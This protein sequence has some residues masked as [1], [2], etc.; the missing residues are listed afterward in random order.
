MSATAHGKGSLLIHTANYVREARG[1]PTWKELVA[2]MS[3]SDRETLDGVLL[4]GSWYPIGVVNR[5]VATFCEKYHRSTPQDE[6]RRLAA[7]IADSDLSSVYKMA[8]R[9][10]SP[11]FL[12]KRTD[13]LWNRYFD[14]GKLTPTELEHGSW[15]LHLVVPYGE[16]IAP[17]TLFCG[18]GVP[19]W[20]EMALKLTGAKNASVRHVECRAQNGTSCSYSA[21]W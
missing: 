6:M 17:N 20:I 12:L 3:P 14:V 5:V 10:G 18:P 11:E 2:G 19:A 15:K 1:E 7:Y 21:S 4:A 13:S 16:E 9:F 8:L